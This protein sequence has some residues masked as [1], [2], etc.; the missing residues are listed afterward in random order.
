MVQLAKEVG[1]ARLE[2]SKALNALADAERIILKRGIIEIP[3][4]QLL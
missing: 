1:Y 3:A 4:L 2:I